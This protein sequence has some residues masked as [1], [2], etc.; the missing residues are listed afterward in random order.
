MDPNRPRVGLALGG[1]AAR[2]VFYIGVLEVLSEAGVP[3]DFISASSS[4]TIVAS[5]FA[6]GKLNEIKEVI[7]NLDRGSLMSLLTKNR[8]GGGLYSLDKVELVLRKIIGGK[9]F[10][11]VRPGLAFAAV[12]LRDSSLTVLAMGDIA[13]AAR[14]SCTVPGL[15]EPISWGNKVLV[16]G[17]LLSVIPGNIARDAGMDLVIG[18]NTRSTKFIFKPH[19]MKLRLLY[20]SIKRV[21]LLN[22]AETLWDR[23]SKTLFNSD[24]FSVYAES[25]NPE[26]EFPGLWT[27]LGKSIDIAIEA[28]TRGAKEGN[29]YGCDHLIT[30]DTKRFGIV[31]LSQTQNL[32]SI[33]R[34]T[35][36]SQ[37]PVIFDLIEK[38]R[39]KLIKPEIERIYA[40]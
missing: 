5:A 24:W 12:D 29:F 20:R 14:I 11:E 8:V 1:A 27:I 23:I 16:D 7:F 18:V 34:E 21:L 19:Q 28:E 9:N 37:L 3:I 17:G 39:L 2:S 35:A 15:F 38:K 22:H 26:F 10:E 6:C 36:E 33:G 4:G 40:S 30:L 13:R 25:E 32:Y 31:D